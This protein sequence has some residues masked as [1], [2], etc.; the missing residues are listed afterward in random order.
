M[1]SSAW[2]DVWGYRGFGL[3]WVAPWAYSFCEIAQ[4]CTFRKCSFFSLYVTLDWKFAIINQAALKEDMKMRGEIAFPLPK[5]GKEKKPDLWSS[6]FKAS[7]AF[8]SCWKSLPVSPQNCILPWHLGCL[9]LQVEGKPQPGDQ[10]KETGGESAQSGPAQALC[11]SRS[12]G[13]L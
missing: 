6:C 11:P 7:W 10:E 8:T 1:A 5:A 2:R 9:E 13:H 12:T 4:S 3:I